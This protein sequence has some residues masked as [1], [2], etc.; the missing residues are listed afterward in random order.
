[1]DKQR[2][3]S[4]DVEIAAQTL[5]SKMWGKRPHL[6][7]LMRDKDT[8]HTNFFQIRKEKSERR[9]RPGMACQQ[10]TQT[11]KGGYKSEGKYTKPHP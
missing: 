8:I 7:Y 5:P 11:R 3:R 9:C 10:V 2:H 6:L 4:V 1:M